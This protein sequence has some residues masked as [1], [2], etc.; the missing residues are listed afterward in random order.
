M[1]SYTG[2]NIDNKNCPLVYFY[3]SNPTREQVV[4][5]TEIIFYF[6][7]MCLSLLRHTSI[8]VFSPTIRMFSLFRI[9]T[10]FWYFSFLSVSSAGVGRW[11]SSLGETVVE[12]ELEDRIFRKSV[13]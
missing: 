4:L 1:D 9:L 2:M 11:E 6:E 12:L 3:S 13:F 5:T 8:F 10:T 7:Y